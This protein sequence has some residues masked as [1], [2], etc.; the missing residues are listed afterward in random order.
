MKSLDQNA[1]F[2][3]KWASELYGEWAIWMRRFLPGCKTDYKKNTLRIVQK[4]KSMFKE[5]KIQFNFEGWQRVTDMLRAEYTVENA[6]GVRII[7]ER[8]KTNK[9]V[10]I[11]RI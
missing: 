10:K 9:D 1:A 11:I 6:K 4:I 3:V 5:G 7:L 2:L 8:F